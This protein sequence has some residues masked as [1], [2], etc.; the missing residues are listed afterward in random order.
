M[1]GVFAFGGTVVYVGSFWLLR[2]QGG[3]GDLRVIAAATLI[4]LA[5]GVS[6]LVLG[7]WLWLRLRAKRGAVLA[8][9]DACL[10]T[11]Q[12]GMVL[13]LVAAGI[14]TVAAIF[15]GLG[16]FDLT[17]FGRWLWCVLQLGLLFHAYERMARK[18]LTTAAPVPLSR[19]AARVAWFGVLSGSFLLILL[20]IG[21]PLWLQ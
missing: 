19:P 9:A 5:A 14:N 20:L 15:V 1:L 2:P 3:L 4:G 18:F 13:L 7:G 21:G 6:W 8:A 10:L 12:R 17:G 16:V 11:M